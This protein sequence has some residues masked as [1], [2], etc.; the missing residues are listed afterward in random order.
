MTLLDLFYTNLVLIMRIYFQVLE[1][2]KKAGVVEMSHT[3]A[4]ITAQVLERLQEG[5]KLERY[6]GYE[7]LITRKNFHNSNN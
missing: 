6:L 7:S 4:T 2:L 3:Q 1:S 5:A